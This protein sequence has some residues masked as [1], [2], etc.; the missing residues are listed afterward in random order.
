[1]MLI[2]PPPHHDI[3]S[4]EDL[5]QL[6]YDL[7]AINPQARIGVKL[8]A[9]AGVGIIATGV[10]KAGADVITISGHDGGT[11]ASPITSIKNTGLP[12]EVGLRDA[13]AM[14][15]KAG[16]RG[17]VRLRVDGGFKFA[18][19]VII[20]ALLGAEEFGFGTASLLALGCVMA[21]QCHLNTCPVG[22]ATQDEKLRTRFTGKPEMVET[23][24]RAVAADVRELLAVDGRRIRSMTSWARRNGCGPNSAG[25]TNAGRIARPDRVFLP[26][27]GGPSEDTS[28]LYRELN[29]T[30]NPCG[31]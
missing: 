7:R 25:G 11:G 28:T 13:H 26:P 23:Y 4:I 2:S 14:L 17:R 16:L 27:A 5:A 10:A 19:D 20:G 29:R 21:R 30:V 3:Y 18:R 9:S 12:W 31:R 22:I 1:M 24:F 15:V 6:I 8:V